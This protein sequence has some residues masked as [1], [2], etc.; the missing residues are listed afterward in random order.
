MLERD[1]R[2]A[3]VPALSAVAGAAR[4]AAAVWWNTVALVASALLLGVYA[5]PLYLAL[6]APASAGFLLVAHRLRRD[7]VEARAW[8]TFKL[9]GVYL[10][11]LLAALVL[12][13]L[14]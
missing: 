5:G 6:A 3:G 12:S 10:L 2:S 7:P 4:T 11:A 9:S 1:Y 8:V 14:A 13:A